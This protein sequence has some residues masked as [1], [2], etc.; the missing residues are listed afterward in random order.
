MIDPELRRPLTELGMIPEASLEDGTARVSAPAPPFPAAR[1]AGTIEADLRTALGSA[2][3]GLDVV[4][5]VG[6]MTPA[7]RQE[8]QERLVTTAATPSRIRAR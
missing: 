2:P 6:V 3:G 4:V 1:C 7:Q 8:L 5:D